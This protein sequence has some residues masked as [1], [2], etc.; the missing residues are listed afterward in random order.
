MKIKINTGELHSKPKIFLT[1]FRTTLLLTGLIFI[2]IV[3]V[4]GQ[5]THLDVNCDEAHCINCDETSLQL[6]VFPTDTQ[7]YARNLET[8]V[9]QVNIIGHDSSENLNTIKVEVYRNDLLLE[10]LS[11]VEKIEYI[12][13]QAE[14][15]FNY[16]LVA[17][18]INYK[19]K[20]I[21]VY[22]NQCTIVKEAN[23]VVA[24][25]V[26]IIT[27]QSNA[28]APRF[29][30]S[31]SSD[32]Y[33]D[34]FIR[35]YGSGDND[36]PKSSD[37]WDWHN[38]QGDS[39]HKTPGNTGQWGLVF[40]NTISK[41]T[42]I[43]VA[44]F[45]GALGNTRICYYQRN[46]DEPRDLKT[47]YGRLLNRL[48]LT[49][50]DTSVR[51]LIWYQ[52]ESD[53]IHCL[54]P[55]NY[56]CYEC[57]TLECEINECDEN[58]DN[59]NKCDKSKYDKLKEDYAECDKTEDDDTY[60]KKLEEL[61]IDWKEDYI[62]VEQFYII[63]VRNRQCGYQRIII[64]MQEAQ[65]KLSN[66]YEDVSLM[67]TKGL[68]YIDSWHYY[69]VDGYEKL[70]F[71][72]SNLVMNDFYGK[73]IPE[74]NPPLLTSAVVYENE[75]N[76]IVLTINGADGF[77]IYQDALK[78]FELLN[79][80]G[81]EYN[82]VNC[83][84]L[85]YRCI[86]NFDDNGV[87]ISDN[88]ILCTSILNNNKLVLHFGSDVIATSLTYYDDISIPE[89]Y[90]KYPNGIGLASFKGFPIDHL[91]SD[92][93]GGDIQDC[94]LPC[95]Q[96]SAIYDDET[97]LNAA[98][99]EVHDKIES[100]GKLQGNKMLNYKAGNCITLQEGFKVE[101]NAVFSALIGSCEEE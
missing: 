79:N 95:Q 43:P 57:E 75:P 5:N 19:F 31:R 74:V 62:N 39:K 58:E 4:N 41:T 36:T 65:F 87:N 80:N 35:V 61:Y 81:P 83:P 59:K 52:G 69:F 12:D 20:L 44:I 90:I 15:E 25:D 85:D 54:H 96:Q 38:A 21:A 23:N 91:D 51:G 26:Y 10:T 94:E 24:G 53:A 63:Q 48:I 11:P 49:G 37:T 78:E 97:D 40:G 28:L 67:T 66:L 42:G 86:P 18:R 33:K 27:G 7:L 101:S 16:N 55:C 64:D 47:N 68:K 73:S 76:K 34:P 30:G 6:T 93:P 88:G 13:G 56:P 32:C 71:W 45:N 100:N 2:N 46:D 98:T 1:S 9:A 22:N 60:Y 84:I 92:Y 70:G 29:N 3:Q 14:F 82:E 72:M 8:N 77:I 17:E 89:H 99:I 50:L